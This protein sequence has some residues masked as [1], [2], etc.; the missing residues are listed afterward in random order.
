MVSPS[1]AKKAK[2]EA[3]STG[4][5]EV[6]VADLIHEER[7][8]VCSSVSDFNFN[9]KRVQKLKGNGGFLKRECKSMVYY[10]HRD[11]RVQDNWAMIYA[12][13]LAL[14][15]NLPLSVVC[16][17]TAKHPESTGCTLRTLDFCLKGLD[18]VQKELQTLNI[19]FNL[20]TAQGSKHPGQDLGDFM[21]KN[22]EKP[23]VVADFSALRPHRKILR[24]LMESMPEETAIFQ[25][26]AHNIVPVIVTSEKQEYAART[27]R[28][29]VMGKLNEFLTEFPP[30]TKHP[31]GKANNEPLNVKER[32]E[33]LKLDKKVKPTNWANPGTRAGLKVLKG[34]GQ[35]R[36]KRYGSKRNDPNENA[37]SNLSP[38]FH[39]GHIAVQRAILYVKQY[40]NGSS[41]D[42]AGF[43]EEAVVR[44]ELADNFCYYNENY[45]KIE[46][47]FDWAKKT[48]KDHASDK[49]EYIYT[50]EE[51]EGA[52]TH[53]ELWNAAQLQLVNDGKI[54]GFMRMYWAKKILEW[55]N[56]PEEAL[57]TA[58]FLNDHYSLDGLDANGYVGC[59][60][61]IVGIH[62]QGWT[63]RAVFGKI[64]YM[65]Y[66]GCKRK[67]DIQRYSAKH[68]GK[69][70]KYKK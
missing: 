23:C 20:I 30:V 17:I 45:D 41:E 18:E 63:E 11:Q 36:L 68:G 67:F 39:I 70:Y 44:R 42:K 35:H 43:I 9:A 38:W 55:T 65:N 50:K 22:F 7:L 40:G 26:D 58:L 15:H 32:L 49:R 56:S 21:I 24:E 66:A 52:K 19:G 3:S 25:V 46:G 53:D 10:M 61:S 6:H 34:F 2:M 64:R 51:F 28:N 8:K 33:S 12:Q 57:E 4:Q 5:S 59:M 27:I 13:K 69:S 54:H 37:L 60:W 31:H 1:P 48:L 16:M 14:E 47:G 29:K 62:D